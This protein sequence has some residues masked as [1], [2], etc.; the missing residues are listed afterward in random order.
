MGLL[1]PSGRTSL[2][3]FVVGGGSTPCCARLS[4]NAAASCGEGKFGVWYGV[5]AASQ[6]PRVAYVRRRC[7]GYRQ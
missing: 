6:L 2:P 1:L 5:E 7:S 3:P 4:G